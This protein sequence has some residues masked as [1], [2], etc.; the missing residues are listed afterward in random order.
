MGRIDYNSEKNQTIKE[1]FVDREVFGCISSL[2]ERIVRCEKKEVSIE[3]DILGSMTTLMEDI[4][5][6][7][8][9]DGS[10][11]REVLERTGA[12][13]ESIKGDKNCELFNEIENLYKYRIDIPEIKNLRV[14]EK[15]KSSR[16]DVLETEKE[17]IVRELREKIAE[18]KGEENF[19][20]MILADGE[21]SEE[22]NK[23]N[24]ADID[25][26]IAELEGCLP[27]IENARGEM[28]EICEW[29]HVS[30]YLHDKLREKGHPVWNDSNVYVWGRTST[31]Q[32]V[33]FDD[34]ISEICNNIEIFEGQKNEWKI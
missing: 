33:L 23:V 20:E 31:G 28:Q 18:L 1:K 15:V 4:I 19:S 2:M 25:E 10:A 32:A 26:R 5:K 11:E 21:I 9:K 17:K 16:S 29:I 13:M 3:K 6:S 30:N 8:R 14:H 34:V 24:Q 27:G 22:T 12:L 7:G